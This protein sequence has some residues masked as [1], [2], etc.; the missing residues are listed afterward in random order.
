MSSNDLKGDKSSI[1]IIGTSASVRHATTAIASLLSFLKGILYLSAPITFAVLTRYPY[2]RKWCGPIGL[3]LTIAGFL[4]SS[5]VTQIWQLIA[6]QGVLAA[7]GS[8]LL[9]SPTT[10]YLDEWFIRRKGLAYGIMLASKSFSGVVLPFA[11]A[12]SLQR[13]G[14]RNTVRAWSVVLV[15]GF[16]GA[17]GFPMAMFARKTNTVQLVLTA[18]LLYFLKPRVI[19]SASTT[20]RKVSFTFLTLPSFWILQSGNIIQSLGYFLPST[21]LGSYA[22]S[23]GLSPEVGTLMIAL[24]NAASVPGSVVM[25]MLNDR[26]D[27][28]NVILISS[29]GSTL[30][31]FVFWGLASRAALL[32]V[33][34][35]LFGFFAGGFSATWSGVMTQMKKERPALDT[36]LAFGLLAGVRGIGNVISGP[37]SSALVG[38]GMTVD[39]RR[40]YESQYEWLIV[41]TGLTSLLG[42]W[43]WGWKECRRLIH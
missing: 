11:T 29:L 43:S 39:A 36:G 3:A 37:L 10:L 1:A 20:P 42:G 12:S 8:G 9:Y 15:R 18:P 6:T 25:G 4:A 22:H 23:I 24:I 41:F 32:A 30:A 31:V 28:S 34:A 33:F 2:L 14:F 21:Y 7:I 16:Q 27:V 19:V 13:F 17:L 40:G 5:F 26:F 35:I 38:K